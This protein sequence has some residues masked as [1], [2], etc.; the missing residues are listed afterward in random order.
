MS[1]KEEAVVETAKTEANGITKSPES[2]TSTET[3]DLSEIQLDK[4]NKLLQA[5]NQLN[6]ELQKIR[7]QKNDFFELVLD[8]QGWDVEKMSKVVKVEFNDK[9][10][11]VLSLMA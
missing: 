11:I 1:T 9:N 5:E 10:Q 2:K 6:A 7:N 4:V 3:I 8:A